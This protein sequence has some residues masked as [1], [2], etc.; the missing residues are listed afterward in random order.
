MTADDITGLHHIGLVVPD[1]GAA[2]ATFRRLGFN[3][4]PPAYP[5][6]PPTPGAEPEPI[7]AGNTHADFPRSFIE[8]L[9]AVPE[10]RASLPEGAVLTPLRL[11]DEQLETAR[12]AMRRTV[13][14]LIGRLDRFEGAHILVFASAD[15]ERTA[16]RLD[17]A[18]LA[19]TGARAAQRPIATADG[20]RL[21]PIEYLD[22]HADGGSAAM[23]P[24]GRIGVARDAPAAVLDAQTGI[25]HPNG[26]VALGEVVLCADDVAAAAERYGRYL[27]V[28]A[29]RTG[30]AASFDLGGSALTIT[31][32]PAFA[33]RFPGERA[34]ASPSLS[35]YAVD[36]ADLTA[37]VDIL[38]DGGVDV[39]TAAGGEPFVPA[40]AA[41]GAAILLRQA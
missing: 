32:P 36:V 26:A 2:I 1:L 11:P 19:H 31:T 27:G 37:A 22:I 21:E 25:D 12:N 15:A 20:T 29:R 38:R 17:A 30:D 33:V 6:L 3:V 16:A 34:P 40:A 28:R 41:H 18:G 4:A 9:A 39:R 35:A 23:L 14:G 8:L 13:A 7:G 10:D 24:E 5:A